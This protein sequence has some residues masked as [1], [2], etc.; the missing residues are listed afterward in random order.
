MPGG[1]LTP[2]DLRDQIKTLGDRLSEIERRGARGPEDW[3]EVGASGEPAFLNSWAN[4]GGSQETLGFRM[5]GPSLMALKGSVRNGNWGT[6]IFQFPD[7]YFRAGTQR[8]I[9]IQTYDGTTRRVALLFIHQAGGVYV[10]SEN[11][12]APQPVGEVHLEAVIAL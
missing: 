12:G 2:P 11:T 7:G 1:H 4:I 9:A 5:V 10:Y 6:E 8:R 3:H